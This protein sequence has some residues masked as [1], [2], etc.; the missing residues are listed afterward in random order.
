MSNCAHC[1]V[2][3]AKE[4]SKFCPKCLGV[5]PSLLVLDSPLAPISANF[6][7]EAAGL[8]I[9]HTN[10]QVAYIDTKNA[11]VL[12]RD[13]AQLIWGSAT[14][15]TTPPTAT[16]GVSTT[17]AVGWMHRA[18]MAELTTAQLETGIKAFLAEWSWM[19]GPEGW[20]EAMDGLRA[21]SPENAGADLPPPAT[22]DPKES[23]PGG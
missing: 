2:Y 19:D 21:L 14:L 1:N 16:D 9:H 15:P 6:I 22:P 3:P 7:N 18:K 8:A 20:R 12:C 11:D 13:L 10:G 5:F 4:G 17:D 23:R